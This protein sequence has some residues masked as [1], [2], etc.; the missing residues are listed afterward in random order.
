MVSSQIV[1]SPGA[2]RW[3]Q[4]EPQ[5]VDDAI[6][7]RVWSFRDVTERKRLEEQLSYQALHDSL[8]GLGN[9]A[10]FEDRRQHAVERIERTHGRLP[11]LF[12][13]VDNFK[14]IND[15]HG[16]S[17]GDAVLQTVAESIVGC[18][19]RADTAARIGGDEFGVLVEQIGHPGEA[20]KLPERI[21]MA[22]RPPLTVGANEVSATVS[23]GITFDGPGITSDQLLCNAALAMYAA[24][25]R[26]GN[27]QAEFEGKIHA[28]DRVPGN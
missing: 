12:L 23:I 2:I 20:I 25:A 7:G 15:W 26:G 16:H 22:R 9:R 1:R 11:V 3:I 24:K 14:T 4:A 18:Q 6:V 13:D 27:R 28:S 19:H 8:T 21:L 17:A 10:L 5:R